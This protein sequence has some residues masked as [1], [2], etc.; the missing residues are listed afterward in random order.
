MDK[1]NEKQEENTSG[2]NIRSALPSK[3]LLGWPNQ[4]GLDGLLDHKPFL[5]HVLVSLHEKN[6]GKT[7]T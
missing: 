4:G 5:T 1:A 2:E 3:I 6:N 7:Y